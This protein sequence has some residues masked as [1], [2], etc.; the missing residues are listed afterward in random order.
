MKST[1][2]F[3]IFMGLLTS[4]A[5]IGIFNFDR[6]QILNAAPDPHHPALSGPMMQRPMMLQS[7]RHHLEMLIYHH[8]N[9]IEMAKL[10]PGRAKHPEIETLA[11]SILQDQTRELAQMQTW[12]KTWYNTEVPTPPVGMMGM[13]RN[14]GMMGMNQGRM[15]MDRGV[16]VLKVASDF[17]REFIY[18]MIPHHQR[19][20]HMAQRI[21]QYTTHPELKTMA[22]AMIKSH[23]A[24]I[25]KMQKWNQM[26]Y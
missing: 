13:N 17:D 4:G 1:R 18:K 15:G 10:A 23:M 2:F 26:W 3:P 11:A 22:E 25:A 20:A 16:E 6:L 7:D 24:E 12:Y 5:M 14:G 21:L 9:A 19:E 8:Q